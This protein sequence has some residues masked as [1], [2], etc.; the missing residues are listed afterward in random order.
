[1][2]LNY[3]NPGISLP[4]IF[5]FSVCIFVFFSYELKE[6]RSII[7]WFENRALRIFGP[8]RDE[9]TGGWKTLHNEDPRNLYSS[10]SI[11]RMIK[12]RR[13]RWAGHIAQTGTR[14]A[15]RIL[16]GKSEGKRPVEDQD[17]G[18]WIILKIDVTE[19]EWDGTDWIDLAQ[20]RNQW[21]ALMNTVMNLRVPY[22]AGKFLR[23]CT[24]G[25]FSRRGQLHVFFSWVGLSPLGTAATSGLLYKPQIIDEGDC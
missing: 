15:Y 24:I 1:V 4:A 25:G 11:I 2:V 12:S 5:T 21:R 16:V 7:W 9:V 10:P 3:L 23:G 19:I 22:N 8:S 13:M 14:N 20:D 6:L 18:V 17:I